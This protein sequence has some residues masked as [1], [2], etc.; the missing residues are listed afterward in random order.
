MTYLVKLEFGN[1]AR[2]ADEKQ[3]DHVD[4]YR[5]HIA[6]AVKA[7]EQLAQLHHLEADAEGSEEIIVQRPEDILSPSVE[8]S[9]TNTGL[10]VISRQAGFPALRNGRLEISRE[11][12]IDGDVNFHTGNIDCSGDLVISGSIISG[13]KVKAENL[14]VKGSIENATIEVSGN[15][16]CEGGIVGCQDHPLICRGS[17][18]CKYLEN[19]RIE[20]KADIFIAGSSLHSRMIA[21]GSIV[22]CSR[23]AML[24][25]GESWAGRSLYVAVIGA[26]WATPTELTVGI[27]PFLARD[28]ENIISQQKALQENL[29]EWRE[30]LDQIEIFR[31]KLSED[32]ESIEADNQALNEEKEILDGRILHAETRSRKM[33]LKLNQLSE[34]ATAFHRNNPNPEIAVYDH[35]F[36]GIQLIIGEAE[37]HLDE[38]CRKMV[39]REKEGEIVISPIES[40]AI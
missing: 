31:Q 35:A 11:L 19:S 23:E 18:W 12:L 25:G 36:S 1:P 5:S 3:A 7:G 28:I 9:E 32:G 6:S 33:G 8:L 30:R 27:D 29:A 17:L 10:T 24:V 34:A 20:V 26:K 13:F 22:F 38:E 39:F 2:S 15:L 21:G 4:H 40:M 14:K 37:K 16:V